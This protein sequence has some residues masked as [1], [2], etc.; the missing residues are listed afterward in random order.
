MIP[1]QISAL[2]NIKGAKLEVSNYRNQFIQ[3]HY[4]RK[5]ECAFKSE[6][7]GSWGTR[8]SRRKKGGCSVTMNTDNEGDFPH[9]Y[10][11]RHCFPLQTIAMNLLHPGPDLHFFSD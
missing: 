7:S 9:P 1:E 11:W 10:T 4:P 2:H 3:V 8:K 6:T 5:L